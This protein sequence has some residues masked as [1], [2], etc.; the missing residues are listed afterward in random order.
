MTFPPPLPPGTEAPAKQEPA[1]TATVPATPKRDTQ[2]KLMSTP[3]SHDGTSARAV[4]DANSHHR[5]K[6]LFPGV[7]QDLLSHQQCEFD[8]M[9]KV[10]LRKALASEDAQLDDTV[11]MK[12]IL[13]EMLPI[14]AK[15]KG[16]IEQ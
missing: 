13:K 7:K 12:N 11:I 4:S 5:V 9:L 16:D 8:A 1:Q 14:C 10:L 2:P 15:I 6:D 3:G